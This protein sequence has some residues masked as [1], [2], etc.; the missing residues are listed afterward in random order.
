MSLTEVAQHLF[1]RPTTKFF[2]ES[3]D[4]GLDDQ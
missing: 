1:L 2:S 4:C 3:L